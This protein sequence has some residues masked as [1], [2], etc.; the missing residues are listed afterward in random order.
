MPKLPK[1]PSIPAPFKRPAVELTGSVKRTWGETRIDRI[2]EGDI[3]R[4]FGAVG[5]AEIQTMSNPPAI[6][7]KAVNAITGDVR[8]WTFSDIPLDQDLR[9]YVPTVFAFSEG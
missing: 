4:D 6:R 8:Y 7:F 2:R 1:A 9:L 3:I 5:H